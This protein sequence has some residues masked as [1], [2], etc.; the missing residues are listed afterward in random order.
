M[1][2]D[3]RNEFREGSGFGIRDSELAASSRISNPDPGFRKEAPHER[4]LPSQAARLGHRDHARRAADRRRAQRVVR[5]R[6]LAGDKARRA[7]GVQSCQ[8]GAD[9]RGGHAASRRRVF[10]DRSR[11]SARSRRE[12]AVGRTRRSAQALAGC[13]RTHRLRAA[14]VRALGRRS[15]DQSARHDFQR[16]WRRGP[17]GVARIVGARRSARRGDPVPCR[18]SQGIFGQRFDRDRGGARRREAAGRSDARQ[19]RGHRGRPRSGA[20]TT[21][22]FPRCVAEARGGPHR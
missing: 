21:E 17:A 16:R 22:A 20:R 4:Q 5:D 11:R 6:S 7:R 19:R 14:A 1:L 10:R 3:S 2:A 9:S 18:L 13:D 8:R 15:A 12:A